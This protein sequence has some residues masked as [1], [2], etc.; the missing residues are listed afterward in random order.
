MQTGSMTFP[1]PSA[2][3]AAADISKEPTLRLLAFPPEIRNAIF[4]RF[5][6]SLDLELLS[7][8]RTGILSLS[9][10][11][12]RPHALAL[13]GVSKRIHD[14]SLPFL[15]YARL[16]LTALFAGWHQALSHYDALGMPREHASSIRTL[17]LQFLDTNFHILKTLPNLE[18]V[19]ISPPGETQCRQYLDDSST[20]NPLVWTLDSINSDAGYAAMKEE[21]LISMRLMFQ[22]LHHASPE[23]GCTVHYSVG[24]K[25]R[26]QLP[27]W[28]QAGRLLSSRTNYHSVVSSHFGLV[29]VHGG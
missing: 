4:R 3:D 28:S 16:T 21:L 5:F 12:N 20:N 15:R 22:L 10:R 9:C 26:V 19:Y 6:S 29:H 17:H 8:K 18:H 1:T 7:S 24:F 13:L 25:F 14:E 2:V 11:C 23:L 27:M